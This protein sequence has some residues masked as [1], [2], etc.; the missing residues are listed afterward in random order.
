MSNPPSEERCVCGHHKNSHYESD[1]SCSMDGYTDE[2]RCIG[3]PCTSYRSARPESKAE[4]SSML[5]GGKPVIG[6]RQLTS[7]DK[8]GRA[9]ILCEACSDYE[10]ARVYSDEYSHVFD[11]HHAL[12]AERTRERDVVKALSDKVCEENFDLRAKV[13][14]LRAA[15][16]RIDSAYT[17]AHCEKEYCVEEARAAL[18]ETSGPRGE[19]T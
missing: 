9:E 12:L 6:E 3:G 5:T 7:A 1:G 8:Q 14:R 18:K 11:T 16:R 19:G 17:A 15:L 2:A 4:T 10:T 13:E